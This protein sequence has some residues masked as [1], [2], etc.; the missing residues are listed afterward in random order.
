MHH[1]IHGEPILQD[2]RRSPPIAL[3][4]A[5]QDRVLFDPKKMPPEFPIAELLRTTHIESEGDGGIPSGRRAEI[6]LILCTDGHRERR[7]WS[8]KGVL[9]DD[10]GIAEPAHISCG[11]VCD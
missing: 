5:G 4:E 3:A 6:S 9:D 8:R 1:A 7:P 11:S 10:I 2:V